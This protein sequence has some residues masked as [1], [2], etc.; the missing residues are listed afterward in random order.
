MKYSQVRQ[1]PSSRTQIRAIFLKSAALQRKQKWTNRGSVVFVLLLILLS[2]LIAVASRGTL[3][4][5][6]Q[7]HERIVNLASAVMPS[8]AVIDTKFRKHF[9]HATCVDP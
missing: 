8:I 7:L 1:A 5:L 4:E 3:A 6:G 2:V 9:Q